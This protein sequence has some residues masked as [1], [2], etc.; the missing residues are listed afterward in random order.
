MKKIAIRLIILFSAI[1]ISVLLW[2]NRNQTNSITS[3]DF[4]LENP[5]IIDKIFLSSNDSKNGYV[6]LTKKTDGNWLV[7][8]GS[9]KYA[10]DTQAINA[11]LFFVM[12][13]LEVKNPVNDNALDN[14]NR[15]L[16]LSGT[17]AVFYSKNKEIR[18]LYAGN[19]TAD[20]L[21]TFMYLPGTERPCVIHITGFNGYLT[22][23][24]TTRINDWRSSVIL[25]VPADQIKELSV[26]WNEDNSKS[27]A[28]NMQGNNPVLKDASGKAIESSR[29]STLAFLDMFTGISRESGEPAGINKYPE[30][31][32]AILNSKP[33]V[34]FI[35]TKADGKTEHLKL[36]RR[37]V[38]SETYSPEDK[39][40][41]LKQFETDTYWGVINNE[42]VLW[43]MQDAVI[44]NRLKTIQDLT[45]K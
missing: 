29:N 2:R 31:K 33:F 19:P 41:N 18:T 17:K 7:D 15:E 9:Q 20:Q 32:N 35:I 12:K 14:V 22:P 4:A 5:G 6:T 3:A 1:L 21:G 45:G 25:D 11:F 26:K 28:I 30:K 42:Q 44:R 16:K 38:G 8:N 24:F 10:G 40:G 23:Y 34:E 39:I 36:F 13:K 27:F 43:I 37:E